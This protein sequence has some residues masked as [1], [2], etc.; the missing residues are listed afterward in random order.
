MK[1]FI[2]TFDALQKA[3]PRFMLLEC[4]EF[5]VK[6]LEP[7]SRIEPEKAKSYWDITPVE[8]AKLTVIKTYQY[9]PKYQFD[10]N[11]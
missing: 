10:A 5:I 4:P 8:T 6:A 9:Q 11:R 3:R 7:K 1:N 2:K